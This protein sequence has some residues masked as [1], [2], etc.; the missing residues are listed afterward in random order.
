[1]ALIGLGRM[2][3]TVA[4]DLLKNARIKIVLVATRSG[5]EKVGRNL[6][7]ILGL[8]SQ[9]LTVQGSDKL[10][11]Y[12]DILRPEIIIDFTTPEASLH[13]LKIAAKRGVHMVVGT[14]GF[15]DLQMDTLRCLASKYRVSLVLAPN[16]S[17]GIN[18]LMSLAKK[19]AS[20]VPGFDVEIIEEHHRFKKDAPSGTA[21]R[22]GETVARELGINPRKGLVFG[23]DLGSKDDGRK[24]F[25]HSIRSG[26]IIGVHKIVFVSD[27]E[28][29]ELK[30]A[31]LNRSAFTDCL[32]EVIEFVHVNTPGVYTV[33]NIL[34]LDSSGK[35]YEEDIV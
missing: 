24:V 4:R 2:G 5:S 10:A 19:V 16:L 32:L 18:I 25:I 21:I 13:N 7:D 26:G 34:G 20:I 22:L 6:G 12:L 23:R 8:P 27:N 17:T 15:T 3:Q 33:E 31:S 29:I 1:M 35:H 14:T 9:N 30:H 28:R 11:E